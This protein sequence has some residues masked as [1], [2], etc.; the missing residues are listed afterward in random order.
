MVALVGLTVSLALGPKIVGAGE[1]SGSPWEITA[2]KIS[3]FENPPSIIAEGNVVLVRKIEGG[4]LAAAPDET[5]R[6]DGEA[7]GEGETTMKPMT[8][9]GDWVRLDPTENTVKVRGQAI[10]DSEDEHVTADVADLNLDTHTGTLQHTTIYF[11]QRSLFLAGENVRKTGELTYYLEDGWVTKCE[12]EDGKA[13]PWSF[14]WTSAAITYEGFAHFYNATLRVKD[15]PVLYSPYFA[16]STNRKRKTGLLLPEWSAGGRDGAGLLVPLFVNLSPSSDLT[17]YAGG[18][19]ERGVATGAEFRMVESENSQAIFALN[20]LKDSLKDSA[21]DEYKSDGIYRTEENRW[22]LRGKADHDFG[23]M[24]GRLDL[25]LVSDRDYLE[26]FEGG[27]IGFSETDRQFNTTFGRGFDSETTYVRS[28]TAQLN[29]TWSDMALNAEMRVVNDPTD[30]RSTYHRWTLPEVTFSGRLPVARKRVGSTGVRE[31]LEDTDLTW[32]SI[33]GFYWQEN[34]IGG[35]RLDLAP[36]LITPLRLSPYLETTAT[37]G[38]KETFYTVD[39]NRVT[40]DGYNSDIYSRTMQNFGLSTS[41]IFMRDFLFDSNAYRSL[42]HMVRPEVSYNYTPTKNQETVPGFVGT[43]AAVNSLG[44]G[45]RNDFDLLAFLADGSSVTRKF[46]Y[47]YVTQAYD[48]RE[49][50]REDVGGDLLRPFSDIAF[51][52]GLTPIEKLQLVYKTAWNVYGKGI[53]RYEFTSQYS[54]DREDS[55]GLEYRYERDSPVNQLNMRALINLNQQ[56]WVSGDISH[57][58]LLDKTS[59]ASLI[60]FYDPDCWSLEFM[61]TTTPDDDFRFQMIVSFEDVGKILGVNQTLYAQNS[62]GYSLNKDS[63]TP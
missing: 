48:I 4:F 45:V 50:R 49:A 32:G 34:D 42:T 62:G 22:W 35:H 6:T 12:L 41:T 52:T 57:S 60:V 63:K 59:D 14:G 23:F 61:A 43:V 7:P 31:F 53:T 18:Y 11:P 36:Q 19:S 40:S 16:F 1:L 9:N 25:D 30:V 3:R 58:F 39:D 2:D 55:L 24:Q 46:G 8:I 47:L 10:L 15:V 17:F 51:E 28:N 44:Y 27:M 26:E 37:L 56:L 20:Y 21:T 5:A 33:Y 29:K 54:N 13:P 38:V